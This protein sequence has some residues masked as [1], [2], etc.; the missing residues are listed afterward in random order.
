MCAFD[1]FHVHLTISLFPCAFDYLSRW[2]SK[3]SWVPVC[4]QRG[5]ISRRQLPVERQ[6]LPCSGLT[7]IIINIINRNSISIINTNNISHR[8]SIG[9]SLVLLA[10]AE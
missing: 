3:D 10:Q 2:L 8:Q 4:G 6:C 1:Y 7:I 5:A 9:A